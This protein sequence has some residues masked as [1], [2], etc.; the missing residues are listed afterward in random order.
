MGGPRRG[1]PSPNGHD[2]LNFNMVLENALSNRRGSIAGALI[3]GPIGQ[4]IGILVVFPA[5]MFQAQERKPGHEE[6]ATGVEGL[7]AGMAHLVGPLDLAHQKLGIGVDLQL[8][9]ALTLGPFQGRDEGRVFGNIIGGVA[10][11]TIEF[12]HDLTCGIFGVNSESSRPRI[13]ACSAVDVNPDGFFHSPWLVAGV[14]TF[15]TTGAGASSAPFCLAARWYRTRP[16]E[17]QG[18]IRSFRLTC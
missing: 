2:E 7:Q 3:H 8:V 18:M 4:G 16:Q 13:T 11:K 10:Q 17:S 14:P 15:S 1:M 5:H 12:S 6:P 9:H